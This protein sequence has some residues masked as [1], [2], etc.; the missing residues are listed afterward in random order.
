MTTKQSVL[1][2]IVKDGV[3]KLTLARSDRG[4]ALS[5]DLVEALLT[6]VN[7]AYADHSVHTLVLDAQGKH[8]CTGFDLSD[9]EMQSD[10]DLLQR[11]VRVEALLAAIWHAPIRTM[12]VAQGRVWG[13]GADL[14]AVCD[15]RVAIGD[16]SFRFP[17]AGFGLV[18]GTRRLAERIGADV[19]RRCVV[20]GLTLDVRAALECGLA[21]A[22][23]SMAADLE[24]IVSA[25]PAVSREVIVQ[26]HDATRAD[27]R[28]ADLSALVRSASLPGLK[29]RIMDYRDRQAR[30]H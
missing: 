1:E 15:V 14:F 2:S 19:A 17:G 13:A 6:A 16:A 29:Q 11:F 10:G 27:C 3:C 5:S 28:D 12:A 26:L 9:V 22:S 30:R 21:V 7:Q 20:D 8:F 23:R 24:G 4:N 25:L 18:L